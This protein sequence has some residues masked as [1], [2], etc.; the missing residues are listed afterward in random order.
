MS[1]TVTVRLT[2]LR[3]TSV[4]IVAPDFTP[5]NHISSQWIEIE[6]IEIEVLI[7]HC[8]CFAPTKWAK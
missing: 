4:D 8:S 2:V 6:Q 5:D 7:N 1:Q 3:H